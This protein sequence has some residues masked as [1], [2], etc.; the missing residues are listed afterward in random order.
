MEQM[1]EDYQREQA[2]EGIRQY[3]AGELGTSEFARLECQVNKAFVDRGK[4]YT[5]LA[6]TAGE[7]AVNDGVTP[8]EVLAR[9]GYV[10]KEPP[11]PPTPEELDEKYERPDSDPAKLEKQC[12][13]Q[14]NASPAFREKYC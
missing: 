13:P 11:P 8:H 12:S 3:E 10:C 2:K 5:E 9:E 1:A 7:Q 6:Q 4:E 14:S